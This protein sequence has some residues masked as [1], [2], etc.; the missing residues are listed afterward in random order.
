MIKKIF[1]LIIVSIF[2][3]FSIYAQLS[4]GS[5][6]THFS[7]NN[8]SEIAQSKDRVFALSNNALFSIDKEYESVKLYSKINGL[9]DGDISRIAYSE[10]NNAL[11]IIYN[12]CNIDILRGENSITNI[13]DIK[14]KEITGKQINSIS[15]SG[16]YAFLSCGFGIVVVNLKK[17]E[18]SDTYIIGENGT[19]ISVN[20]VQIASV[21]IY[22]LPSN[23]IL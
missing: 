9:N 13:S 22:A 11:I 15:F 3:I 4:M 7:Y 1:F 6:D 21:N 14:R 23:G 17:N 8:V 20:S 18:I 5:W 12:N 2:S 10:D 19:Y 16:E